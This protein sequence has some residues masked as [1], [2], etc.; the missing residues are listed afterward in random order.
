MKEKL[1]KVSIITV[2]LN[3]AMVIR[4]A[5]ES[6]GR[7]TYS[8]IEYLVIDG[9]STDGTIEILEEYQKKGQ[10]DFI[11]ESDEG[12]YDAM[13]K[14]LR[15][16]TGDW[17]Y[18]LGSDDFFVDDRILEKFFSVDLWMQ[19]VIY[20]NVKFMHSGCI[21]DGKF[22]HEK[23]SGKNICHQA[24]FVRKTLYQRIGVFN[25]KYKISAD[26][27]FN[28]R[29]IGRN[30]PSLYFDEIIAAYN[31]KGISS[32]VWDQIFFDDFDKL[33]VENN[34]ICSRSLSYLKNKSSRLESSYRYRIG[35]MI[36]SPL[37][38]LKTKFRD[39]VSR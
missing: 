7:Q 26:Y 2:C 17:V 29:W 19:E 39:A 9:G 38:W 25:T 30:I 1:P 5:I 24:L 22:D 6:V 27:E 14:G 10:L 12:I 15:M 11:S 8:N 16:V 3:A 36:I 32:K 37:N 13:N 23:I 21:Y 34:I 31:E 33:L 28:L 35:V 4:T 20:G 18:F